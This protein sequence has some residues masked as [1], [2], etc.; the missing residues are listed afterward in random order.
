MKR[1]AEEEMG[2]P[3]AKKAKEELCQSP[4]IKEARARFEEIRARQAESRRQIE[5]FKSQIRELGWTD[6]E[7]E[8]AFQ[9]M[10]SMSS[11]AQV[12]SANTVVPNAKDSAA[13]NLAGT[14]EGEDMVVD[15][16]ETSAQPGAAP[17]SAKR[18]PAKL[19]CPTKFYPSGKAYHCP[20]END[21][22]ENS[23]ELQNGLIR[24]K[25][26]RAA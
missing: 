13:Q 3:A 18:D 2:A 7:V 9:Q 6:A 14:E 1:S 4:A 17:G 16:K 26:F 25:P 19:S 5:G 20:K 24:L 23:H 8:A 11:E 12:Q 22:C 10:V 21:G 15:G